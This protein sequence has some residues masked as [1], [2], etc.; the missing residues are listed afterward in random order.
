MTDKYAIAALN[1]KKNSELLMQAEIERLN[2][3]M[4][5]NIQLN[6]QNENNSSGLIAEQ[7]EVVELINASKEQM[8]DRMAMRH[9]TLADSLQR[10]ALSDICA[11]GN[12]VQAMKN[13]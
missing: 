7:A 4:L 2:A 5:A 12:R 3:L 9:L 8:L 13:R 10:M 11:A 1:A 6:Q